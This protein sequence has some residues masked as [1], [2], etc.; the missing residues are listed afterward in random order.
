MRALFLAAATAGLLTA[1]ASAPPIEQEATA[2]RYQY[3]I[4]VQPNISLHRAYNDDG[5]TYLEFLDAHRMNPVV[6]TFDGVPLP[7]AWTDK[8]LILDGVYDNLTV[9][10][11]HGVAHVYAKAS[12]PPARV[13][14]P[15][16]ARALE[17]GAAVPTV[18]QRAPDNYGYAAELPARGEAMEPDRIS[19]PIH[20]NFSESLGEGRA[21]KLVASSREAS[22]I[23]IGATVAKRDRHAESRAYVRIA[24]ARQF[25]IDNGVSAD[26]IRTTKVVAGGAADGQVN[27]LIAY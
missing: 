11:P 4:D 25:L 23:I 26:R 22:R 2:V 18:R 17:Y 21:S 10:T 6:T 8:L 1:C 13:A 3:I 9:T 15:A 16:P 24:E 7:Y 5:H 12:A 20:G 14:A 19:V 27:F